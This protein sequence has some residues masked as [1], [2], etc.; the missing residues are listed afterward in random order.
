MIDELVSVITPCYNGEGYIARFLD[1]ILGQTYPYVE[2]IIIDDGS[3]DKTASVIESYRALFEVKGYS[4]VYKFQKNAGQAAALNVGLKLFQGEYLVWADSDDFFTLDSIQKKVNYLRNNEDLKWMRTDLALVD[5]LDVNKVLFLAS[6]KLKLKTKN[7]FDDLVFE[8][9]AYYWNGGYML[10]SDAFLAVN[11]QREIYV[12]RGGQ[13]AQILFPMALVYPCGYLNEVTYFYVQRKQSHS[14]SVLTKEQK[15]QYLD[16]G[17]DIALNVIK[18]LNVDF[19]HYSYQIK[20]RYNKKRFHVAFLYKDI[21]Q[22]KIYF[23]EINKKS[24]R[25]YVELASLNYPPLGYLYNLLKRIKDNS[26]TC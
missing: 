19:G 5:E 22:A 26:R 10:K 6:D 24:F 8:R 13:N 3:T 23:K 16:F 1:S 17:E 7:I 21:A 12:S 14:H 18:D 2:L 4:L 9:N 15:V 20:E 11:P 25:E